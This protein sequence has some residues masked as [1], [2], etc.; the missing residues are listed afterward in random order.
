MLQ[1]SSLYLFFKLPESLVFSTRYKVGK[2]NH[3]HM[4]ANQNR[5]YMAKVIL[6]SWNLKRVLKTGGGEQQCLKKNNFL[7]IWAI[8][9]FRS[10]IT[11]SALKLVL[12][13]FHQ[14]T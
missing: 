6:T 13:G 14:V 1:M 4:I 11:G 12:E 9:T 7:D 3:C 2:Y 5:I 10:R 8:L